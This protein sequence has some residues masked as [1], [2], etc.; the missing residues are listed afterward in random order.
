MERTSFADMYCSVART[1]EVVGDWWTL[2]IL[3]DVFMGVRRFDEIQRS[4]GVARNILSTRL[5]GLVDSGILERRPYQ[6]RPPRYEYIL[7]EKGLDL[8]P[9]VV[10]LSRWGDRWEFGSTAAPVVMVHRVC[11]HDSE[12][13]TVCS[14]CGSA[15]LADDVEFVRP[16]QNHA[17]V[18]HLRQLERGAGNQR[19][20]G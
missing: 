4:L 1:L 20:S 17:D 9:I 13:M 8:F 12:A 3:R 7:T 14:H 2:L 11:G 16:E 15:L 19:L 18:G 10:A 6:T 5:R